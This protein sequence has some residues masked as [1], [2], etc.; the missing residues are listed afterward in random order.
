MTAIELDIIPHTERWLALLPEVETYAYILC[1]T[2]FTETAI[3]TYVQEIELSLTLADDAYIQLLNNKYRQ[4][5]KPTNVLSFPSN[6][7]TPPY[8]ERIEQHEG[9]AMLGD[10]VMSLDT[11]EREANAQGKPLEA[12]FAHLL[13]HGVL[14]LLGYDHETDEEAVIMEELE[15]LILQQHRISCPYQGGL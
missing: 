8:F 2:V 6:A 7:L 13:V 3:A 9:Y 4:K 10:I 15:T 12:H 14:H 5:D 11:L 1:Q